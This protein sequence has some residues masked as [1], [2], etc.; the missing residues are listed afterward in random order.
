MYNEQDKPLVEDKIEL[1]D[2][3][4][5]LLFYSQPVK[6]VTEKKNPW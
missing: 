3:H 5:D 4:S 6:K 1:S 2:Q